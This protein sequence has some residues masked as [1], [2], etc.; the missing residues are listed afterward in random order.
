[1][2]D[3]VYK[4]IWR[5]ARCSNHFANISMANGTLKEEKK[6]CKCKS[7]NYLTL[8]N[9]D[10]YIHCRLPEKESREYENTYGETFV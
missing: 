7:V 6:C 10:I 8:T 1:M 5:C 9:G 3:D 2:A 4:Y